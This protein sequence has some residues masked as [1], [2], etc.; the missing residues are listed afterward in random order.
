M[1]VIWNSSVLLLIVAVN[2]A[3]GDSRTFSTKGPKGLKT[4][5]L[6]LAVKIYIYL[7]GFDS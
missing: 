1:T 3:P 6:L 7:Q 4:Q 2:C 5:S